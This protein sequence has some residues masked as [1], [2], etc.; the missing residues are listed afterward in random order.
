MTTPQSGNAGPGTLGAIIHG[1]G[2]AR[3]GEAI[4]LIICGERHNLCL[5]FT[6][7]SLQLKV[8]E[9]HKHGVG[10]VLSS[11]EFSPPLS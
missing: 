1:C 6:V 7:D 2:R 11:G 8:M 9:S 5:G 3:Q 4:V 10:G